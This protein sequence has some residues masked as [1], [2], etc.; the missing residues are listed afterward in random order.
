MKL[1]YFYTVVF[2]LVSFPVASEE[3]IEPSG[4][5]NKLYGTWIAE[6][7]SGRAVTGACKKTFVTY[8]SD[9]KLESQSGENISYQSYEAIPKTDKWVIRAKVIS[10]NNKPNCQGYSMKQM[11]THD[12]PDLIVNIEGDRMLWYSDLNATLPFVTLLKKTTK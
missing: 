11:D 4:F 12:V 5:H 3:K 1:K 9:G 6:T 7:V 10:S 8:K 2:L